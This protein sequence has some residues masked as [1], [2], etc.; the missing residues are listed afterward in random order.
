[1]IHIM[2]SARSL[3]YSL[4]HHHIGEIALASALVFVIASSIYSNHLAYQLAQ[5]ETKQMEQ[6]AEATRQLIQADE[7]T[8]IDFISSIIEGNTTIPVYMLDQDGNIIVTRNVTEPV[9]DPTTLLGPI[10]V[11][12]DDNTIQYIYYD[13]SIALQ[14]LRLL[15]YLSFGIIAIFIIIAIAIIYT[16][17]RSEQ[18]RVWAGLSKETAHQL[19]TPISS[20]AAWEELLKN[21]YPEDELIPQ[22]QLDINRLKDIAERFSKVGSEPELT[23]QEIVPVIK[24]TVE[25][26]QA[27]ISNKIELVFLYPDDNQHIKTMLNA[28]L[29][30]WVLEN[31]IKNAIDAMDGTGHINIELSKHN[32]H[33]QIDVSD[34]GKGIERRLYKR[35]FSPGYTT[36]QRGWGLGLSLSKRIVED[37]HRGKLFVQQ[38]IIGQCTTFRIILKDSV[39]STS[40]A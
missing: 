2:K 34:T 37:Y 5:T 30:Q 17:Q 23:E 10:E 8:D 22:M 40:A 20:L 31:L 29:F 1:M 36:K 9:S 3:I 13:E 14:R 35:I 28:S 4:H 25:Y 33:I 11:F 16:A 6:W 38:S 18:N 24:N 19:G 12:I 32:H 26:M 39:N 21:R 27:R 7:N 15:P